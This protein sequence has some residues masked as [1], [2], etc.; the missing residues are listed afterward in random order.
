MS[1]LWKRLEAAFEACHS[2]EKNERTAY[3][4]GLENDD[5]EL[6]LELSKMLESDEQAAQDSFFE[7]AAVNRI[8]PIDNPES[9]IGTELGPYRV[10]RVVGEGGMGFVFEAEQESPIRRRVALKV[11]R[12]SIVSERAKRRFDLEIQTLARLDHDHIAKVFLMGTT[13]QGLAYFAME[14]VDGL[15]LGDYCRTHALSV[16]ER[17][18]LFARICR[19]V[20]YAHQ[21][22][23]IHRDLKPANIL[24]K[25]EGKLVIP[26]IIDFGIAKAV[27]PDEGSDHSFL[28][29][30]Q[31]LTLP[32]MAVGTLSYMSP[33]QTHVDQNLV[34]LRCDVYSLGVLLYEM[35]VG[36][37]PL[38]EAQLSGD[39]WDQAFKNIREMKPRRPSRAVLRS[40][41]QVAEEM[42]VSREVLA[43]TYRRDL[44]WIVMKALEKEPDRR[45]GSAKALA[46]DCDRYLE[47]RPVAAGP[48]SK[49]YQLK[50][51]I[52]RN[53]LLT[54]GV[55][56]LLLGV[57]AGMFGLV[58][59]LVRA[60]RAEVRIREEA[61]TAQKT[62]ELL[63]EFV[64]SASPV[65]Y[66]RDVKVRDQLHEFGPRIESA[67]W[68][69]EVR[70][71]LNFIIGK[72]YRAV[73]DHDRAVFHMERSAALRRR[74]L[75]LDHVDTLQAQCELAYL[76]SEWE[77]PAAQIRRF[78]LLRDDLT[79]YLAPEHPLAVETRLYLLRAY[80]ADGAWDKAD[81]LSVLPAGFA[82]AS[83][84]EG[85]YFQ[86]SEVHERA[87]VAFGRG[88]FEA[89]RAMAA[90]VPVADPA[91]LAGRAR[92]QWLL[93]QALVLR[94]GFY[95]GAVEE[96]RV[97]LHELVRRAER[98][99][100]VEHTY[101]AM[102]RIKRLELETLS[103]EE[104]LDVVSQVMPPLLEY[105]PAP[106]P[107]F[108]AALAVLCRGRQD[109]DTQAAAVVWM[110]AFFKRYHRQIRNP[111]L[112]I[113][114]LAC[115]A[116]VQHQRHPS[117]SEALAVLAIDHLAA[118]DEG[119]RARIT[120]MGPFLPEGDPWQCLVLEAGTATDPTHP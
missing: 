102:L 108:D 111:G 92:F 49:L 7:G 90:G 71:S 45:Y 62:I 26:K 70:A 99:Y 100:G 110:D 18:R 84:E 52:Q 68:R 46:D 4:A 116:R 69:P 47:K 104:E 95:L 96:A 77:T 112:F 19:A 53:S 120:A 41:K 75:G 93:N 27:E 36:V 21:R 66:G 106:V 73:G 101:A 32:G 1:D 91:A 9:L 39:A 86:L 33:E 83:Y 81:A 3:L 54:A 14:F 2:M 48:P 76:K 37:L 28:V 38:G 107:V 72:A 89:C 82:A 15:P 40:G 16:A 58:S 25:H 10:L 80:T 115:Y 42:G 78:R 97:G 63:E 34:D 43:K 118:A 11:M 79:R 109:A 55:A 17:L 29:V 59:G 50:R 31:Q 5:P 56:V 119:Q 94:A 88:R 24:I 113:D 35:L 103:P 8:D 64:V 30:S 51:F 13:D 60:Q 65:N 12:T 61:E 87:L 20:H 114:W 67:E 6:F 22:G 105:Y 74:L 44:D 23:I 85:L 117:A 98:W 57:V